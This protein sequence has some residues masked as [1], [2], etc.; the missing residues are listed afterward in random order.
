MTEPVTEDLDPAD[1]RIEKL[2]TIIKELE[3]R[4]SVL[5]GFLTTDN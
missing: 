1:Q 5:E 3:E 4:I 2:E